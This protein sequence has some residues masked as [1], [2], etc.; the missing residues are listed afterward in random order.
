MAKVLTNR[1]FWGSAR[2][3]N[4]VMSYAEKRVIG[5][6]AEQ[7]FD[8]VFTVD[9]YPSFVPW[10]KGADV[11]KISERTLEAELW[12]GFP[13]LNEH[14]MSKVTSLYPNVV[15][16]ICTDGRLFHILDTTWRFGPSSYSYPQPSC[17]LHFSLEFEFKSALH[18]QLSQMF[19]GQVVRKMV[20][21]FLHRAEY[22]YGKPSFDHFQEPP[23]ILT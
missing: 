1:C 22:C 7:M 14:Y 16:S 19:F 10:C 6:S 15:H 17:T 20:A 12:I 4:R 8:V 2:R 21:A 9:D 18:A 5:F 3:V 23:D 11:R 13:P